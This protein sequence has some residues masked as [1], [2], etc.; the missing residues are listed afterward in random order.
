MRLLS[1]NRLPALFAAGL[2]CGVL[3]SASGRQSGVP[4]SSPRSSGGRQI[5]LLS[6]KRQA[7]PQPPKNA[8]PEPP[9]K[10]Q[11]GDISIS[12][13]KTSGG[14]FGTRDFHF[15]GPGTEIEVPDKASRSVLTLHADDIEGTPVGKVDGGLI[16]LS[17]NVRYRVVQKTAAGERVLEGTAGHAEV[18]RTT[19]HIDLTRGVR[20]K[21]VDPSQFSGPAT[22]RTTNLHIAMEQQQYHYTLDG[23]VA[24]NDVQFTPLQTPKLA[25]DAK[26]DDKPGPPVP[27][28][29]IHV[30]GFR[31]GD[32][33]F[34]QSIHL[35]GASTT[36]DFTGPEDGS[37]WHLQGEELEGEFV[38]GTSDLQRAT[39]MENVKFHVV[40]P[41][42]DKKYKITV[43]GITP[44]ASFVRTEKGQELVTHAPFDIKVNDPQHLEEPATIVSQ[45]SVATLNLRKVGDNL[46]YELDDDD[47]SSSV[48]IHP[49]H[50]E[51]PVAK[52]AALP[53]P[54]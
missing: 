25:K 7:T 2:L 8:K 32:L 18:R 12:G 51:E 38:S 3:Q 16:V 23:P 26:K 1:A 14:G 36:C 37:S 10:T 40:H 6:G 44:Q 29:K 33:Q 43:D 52:P 5:A 46:L 34:G 42:T 50:I 27:V 35:K 13:F 48:N 20:A 28:G 9:V 19:Q 31:S 41:S 39:A 15:K 45:K 24:E 4:A 21:L 49:K 11:I 17:G 22:L 30:F 47:H 54:K 53:G